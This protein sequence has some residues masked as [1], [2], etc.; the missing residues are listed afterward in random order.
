MPRVQVIGVRDEAATLANLT[1]CRQEDYAL[2][3]LI[4]LDLYLPDRLDGL[5]IL[6]QIKAFFRAEGQPIAPVVVFSHSDLPEDIRACYDRGA[7]AYM[8][9]SPDFGQWLTYFEE[10]RRY[11][12]ETV[13]LPP[14]AYQPLVLSDPAERA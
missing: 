10:L 1:T 6:E 9:K 7:K 2:P 5:R 12:L 3:R 4:L 14:K 13:T 8:I 11:R